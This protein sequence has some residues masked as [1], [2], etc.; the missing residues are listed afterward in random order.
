MYLHKMSHRVTGL[1]AQALADLSE[2]PNNIVMQP[3]YTYHEP[4]KPQKL[5]IVLRKFFSGDFTEEEQIIIDFKKDH[6]IMYEKLSDKDIRSNPDYQKMFR[7]MIKQCSELQ[8][9]KNATRVAS[10]VSDLALNV[11]RSNQ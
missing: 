6:P 1:T 9:G 10:E 8:N 7:F 2:Q 4:W 3:E 11:V 5:E